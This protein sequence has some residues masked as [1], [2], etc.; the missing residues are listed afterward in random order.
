[1]VITLWLTIFAGPS[2]PAQAAAPVVAVFSIQDARD[3]VPLPDPVLDELT[4]YLSVRV[5]E[6]GLYRLTP[7]AL[8]RRA[9]AD[10]RA[11]RYRPCTDELCQIELG[12]ALAARKSLRTRI[13]QVDSRT[14]AVTALLYDLRTEVVERAA[15]AEGTCDR[16]G[17]VDALR[18]VVAELRSLALRGRYSRR[19]RGKVARGDVLRAALHPRL[20]AALRELGL[21]RADLRTDAAA[22]AA[23]RGFHEALD[24]A[25]EDG[26]PAAL[27][28]VIAAAAALTIR[29]GFLRRRL[30]AVDAR[31]A[32][33]AV[34]LPADQRAVL[35]GRYSGLYAQ[36]DGAYGLDALRQT[37]KG[38]DRFL[39]EL[40]RRES[41]P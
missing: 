29:P 23:L 8:V 38:I 6:G 32:R 33:V 12:R 24:R 15:T 3:Q 41:S 5:A 35:E 4:R 2:R 14:C 11:E 36:L 30:N 20:R 39:A 7:P 26:A 18:A 1:M 34:R 10:R 16:D 21:T 19:E 22:A 27:R 9:L 40:R 31:V 28:R 25:D 17:I 37:A 13:I